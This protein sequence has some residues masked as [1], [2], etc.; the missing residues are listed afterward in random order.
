LLTPLFVISARTE[1]E[2]PA[3]YRPLVWRFLLKLPE[4]TIAFSDLGA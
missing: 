2:Y 3:R 1:G 4:N